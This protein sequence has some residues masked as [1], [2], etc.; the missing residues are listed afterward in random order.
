MGIYNSYYFPVRFTML[1]QYSISFFR[2]LNWNLLEC[3][4]VPK[5]HIEIRVTDEF[6]SPDLALVPQPPAAR[7]SALGST[8]LIRNNEQTRNT[9][10]A[11]TPRPCTTPNQYTKFKLMIFENHFMQVVF[12]SKE[13]KF[14]LNSFLACSLNIT[15][16]LSVLLFYVALIHEIFGP[17]T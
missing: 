12:N 2:I 3:D 16:I 5:E 15:S 4:W 8:Q 7:S 17:I 13:R 1:P 10:P 14:I 11:P 9:T 6:L